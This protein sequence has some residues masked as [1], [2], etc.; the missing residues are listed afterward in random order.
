[1]SPAMFGPRFG[2]M[3]SRCADSTFTAIRSPNCSPSAKPKSLGE[4]Y[5]DPN[6]DEFLAHG[7]I[8]EGDERMAA[9]VEMIDGM[10]TDDAAREVATIA[11]EAALRG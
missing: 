2:L 9:A 11:D 7:P 4:E 10:K 3:L 6:I 8:D 1:M 5:G